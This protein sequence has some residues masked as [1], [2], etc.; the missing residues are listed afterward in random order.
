M[1]KLIYFNE[2]DINHSVD[3][4]IHEKKIDKVIS[5]KTN[6]NVGKCE[7][8][9]KIFKIND[10]LGQT[11]EG[12]K[13]SVELILEEIIRYM[14]MERD[15]TLEVKKA[16]QVKNIFV[17]IPKMMYGENAI[18][19]LRKRKIIVKPTIEDVYYKILGERELNVNVAVFVS[20]DFLEV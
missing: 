3:I 1:E 12:C 4:A 20:V 18:D 2:I 9:R 17:T 5:L 6:I 8:I 7:I 16:K 19:L 15:T 11:F 14:S 13:I 10:E